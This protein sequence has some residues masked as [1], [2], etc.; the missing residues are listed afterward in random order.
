[1]ED[2]LNLLDI[3]NNKINVGDKVE[4]RNV[5]EH[6]YPRRTIHLVFKK[7][8]SLMIKDENDFDIELWIYSKEQRRI[9]Q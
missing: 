6:I 2:K 8:N 5:F 3:E 4:I 9:I 1:M 7:N